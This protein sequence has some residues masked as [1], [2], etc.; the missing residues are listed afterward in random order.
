MVVLTD[1]FTIHSI[2]GHKI[3]ASRTAETDYQPAH[4]FDPIKAVTDSHSTTPS[5]AKAPQKHH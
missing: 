5:A 3:K 2:L 4:V 1:A